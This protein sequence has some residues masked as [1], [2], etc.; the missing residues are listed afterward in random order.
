MAQ[1]DPDKLKVFQFILFTKLEGAVTSA[2]VHLGDH[3]G[4]YRAM[5][6]AD[7][8]VTTAHLAHLTQ[9][10]ERWI[11]EWSY[12]QA[13]AKIISTINKPSDSPTIDDDT[14]FLSPEQ[15][16]VL[17]LDNHP[18]FGMGMFHGLPQTMDSLNQLPES[19]RTGIGH[20]YDS[21]GSQ[22]AV[23]IERNFEP[24]S[25]ANLISA[26][27]PKLDGVTQ[28]LS[29]G[30]KVADVGCGAG[31]AVLLMGKEFP[32][33]EFIGYDI[34]K[35][36]LARAAEKLKASKLTNATFADPRDQPMP[37]NNSVDLIT[38]FDCI[39][40]MTHPQQMMN[41]IRN[42]ITDN[43]TWLLVDIKAHDTFTMNATKNPMAALLYGVSVMSCMSSS[44]S[45]PGG[46]GLG[47]LGLS[48]N[49]AEQMAKSAGFSRFTKLDIEHAVNA[50]YEIRP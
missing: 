33:T 35:F 3:L 23:S 18:A 44:M 24:W 12:N 2:M 16:A 38:T 25:N 4:I 13:A 20:N 9:L 47:T 21:K 40:D 43:G 31:G 29:K 7:A 1:I 28:V 11:R 36:A 27:L 46:A 30:A 49:T 50:F 48:A 6:S 45:Q 39:H 32:K 14:F 5:A 19:F 26:V 22:G 10:N 17:A 15:T 8:P 37:T 34:S 41:A 42:A